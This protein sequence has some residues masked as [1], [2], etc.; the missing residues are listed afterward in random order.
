MWFWLNTVSFQL[1]K[2]FTPAPHPSTTKKKTRKKTS[3]KAL[4][5]PADLGIVLKNLSSVGSKFVVIIIFL[6]VHKGATVLDPEILVVVDHTD[7]PHIL[8]I[9][10]E[11]R[12][13]RKIHSY[14]ERLQI[15]YFTDVCL[16]V[17]GI[18]RQLLIL[19]FIFLN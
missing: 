14:R 3:R 9:I 18:S 19:F 10:Q 5:T 13:H 8:E 12:S 17:V 16:F 11:I 6:Y 7:L 4:L 15:V 1:W 2:T